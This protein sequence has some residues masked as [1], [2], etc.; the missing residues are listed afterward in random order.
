VQPVKSGYALAPQGPFEL[1][2]A[3]IDG[4]VLTMEPG[5]RLSGVVL[6]GTGAP[7]EGVRV[8]PSP[9]PGQCSGISTEPSDAEGRFTVYG[10]FAAEYRISVSLPGDTV[11]RRLDEYAPIEISAGEHVE[12]IEFVCDFSSPGDFAIAGHV[13]DT[14]GESIR[15]VYVI[16]ERPTWHETQTGGDGQFHIEGL[17]DADFEMYVWHK[18][19]APQRLYDIPAGRDGMR[20]VLEARGGIEGYV[21]DAATGSPVTD[22]E[23]LERTRRNHFN[24]QADYL[25]VSDEN[26]RFSLAGVEPGERTVLVRANGYAPETSDPVLVHPGQTVPELIVR[27]SAGRIVEGIVYDPDGQPAQ[28][29]RI[30][31]DE[32]PT[33]GFVIQDYALAVTGADGRFTLES[34]PA[35]ATQVVAWHPRHAAAHAPIPGGSGKAEVELQLRPGATL[36]GTVRAE[37]EP[38]PNLNVTI[39]DFSPSV[40]ES[41]TDEAGKYTLIGLSAGTVEVVSNPTFGEAESWYGRKHIRTVE[42][43]EGDI[44][45]LD[46]DFD[47]WPT[48]VAGRITVDG[49]PPADTLY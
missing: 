2:S 17:R 26:G 39:G 29:A 16:A 22:F 7:I 10:L 31:L 24:G 9:G 37:G 11:Y 28:E 3:G 6:S 38:I 23:I 40:H 27:L 32:Q 49:Q 15:G 1:P 18:Q 41:Q 34:V 47:V 5:A 21:V 44:T 4:L 46:L 36:E 14:A 43:R 12:G 35:G 42:V 25:R 30:F 45:T 48:E 19:Y 13:V 8:L 33:V 20:I